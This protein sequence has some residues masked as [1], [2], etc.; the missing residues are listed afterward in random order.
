MIVMY[1]YYTSIDATLTSANLHS[2]L[3]SVSDDDLGGVLD[4]GGDS[5]EEVITKWRMT[6]P[7]SSWKWLAALCFVHEEEKAVD[8]V[9]KRFKRKLGISM[10]ITIHR[11]HIV[12]FMCCMLMNVSMG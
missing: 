1:M 7:L 11:P 12:M 8:E 9:K 6:T 10:M 4:V 2:A 3:A 5:R